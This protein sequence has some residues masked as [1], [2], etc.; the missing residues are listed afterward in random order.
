MPENKTKPT[1]ASVS[2]FIKSLPEPRR[3]ALGKGARRVAVERYS[4]DDIGRRL[5]E[6]YEEAVAAS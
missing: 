3:A 5:V 6:I 1:R 2:S 4:W